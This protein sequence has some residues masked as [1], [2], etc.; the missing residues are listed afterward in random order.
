M[1]GAYPRSEGLEVWPGEGSGL[2]EAGTG[3]SGSAGRG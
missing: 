1:G 2:G 3:G